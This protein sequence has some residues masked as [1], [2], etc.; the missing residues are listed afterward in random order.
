M[1]FDEY[2]RHV[3]AIAFGKKIGDVVYIHK[4]GL[5]QIPAELSRLVAR[6]EKALKISS[7]KFNL[8]KFSKSD[9]R[10]SLLSYPK[11]KTYPY[12]T[13]SESWTVDL[14]ALGVRKARFG[15]AKNPPILHRRET[16]LPKNH[17]LF[18]TFKKFSEQGELKGLYEDPK[19]IGS[20]LGWQRTLRNKGFKL[21]HEGNLIALELN[22]GERPE[23]QASAKI[24]RHRT[25]LSRDR[26]SLPLF[27]L[28][29]HGY[30]DG[31]F[32]VLDFGCGRGDDLRELEAHGIDCIGWDPN[33]LPETEL[34]NCDLVNLGYVINVIEDKDERDQTLRKAWS[35]TGKLLLVSA[36][37]GNESVFEKY[38]PYKDG[39]LTKHQTFQK[40]YFQNELKAY[41]ESI[42]NEEALALAPGIFLVFRDNSEQQTFLRNKQH[43]PILWQQRTSRPKTQGVK[44]KARLVY[45]KN[46]EI[47][48]EYWK[49][50]LDYGRPI[51][52]EE[53][54]TS[55]ALRNACGSLKKAFLYCTE[56]FDRDVF[57]RNKAFR[58]EDLLVYLALSFFNKR[59]EIFSRMPNSLQLDIKYFFGQYTKARTQA[60][61]LLYSVADI[62]I[63]ESACK[64][65]HA[66]LPASQLNGS[67]DFIFH[68]D[69]LHE[70]PPEIRIYV[71]CAIQL[72]GELEDVDLIK[73][74][75]LSGK[76]T[77]LLYDDWQKKAPLLKERIKIKLRE[78]DID[79]FDYCGPF[80]PQPLEDKTIF[81]SD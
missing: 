79:F 4:D 32:T 30:L 68:K 20:F 25:A 64:V 19:R 72:Y 26:L 36:M 60:K 81:I 11:F 17:E 38:Q 27:L 54:E 34:E 57:N 63:L 59:R 67:H 41:I 61:E 35:F 15:D 2:T 71:G 55:E 66:T 6:V 8:L 47:L 43:R 40:Y 70:C 13:L 75:I 51:S 24:E 16:F 69:F 14:N 74:H 48:E 65:A 50:C 62:N 12:P 39:V 9:F 22:P 33:F 73:V 23:G 46:K 1:N 21:D 76:V 3:K 44:E 42:L 77:L 10:F 28:S 45:A 53:F 78:Q 80:E 7:T 56:I 5:E 18:E 37:L 31:K 49:S 58:Q 52:P 29:K